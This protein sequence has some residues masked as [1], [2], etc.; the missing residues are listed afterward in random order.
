VKGFDG[1][2]LLS[3]SGLFEIWLG[4]SKFYEDP[5]KAIRDAVQSVG[6]H[7]IP[8]FLTAEKAMV[9]GHIA[10]DIP[11]RQQVIDLFKSQTSSDQLLDLAVFPVLIAYESQAVANF[12][13]VSTAYVEKL[14]NEIAELRSYF[15]GKAGDL[16]LRFRL[17][18]IPMDRKADLVA[19]FD[20]KLGAFL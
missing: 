5:K 13:S 2:H 7:I 14:T 16:T 17:I 6:D 8:S 10:P 15:A 19:S 9:F 4:E 11:N 18:F 20:Q 1:I 3:T 12:S